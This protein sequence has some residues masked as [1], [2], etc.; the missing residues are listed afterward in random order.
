MT[1]IFFDKK[2]YFTKALYAL[3]KK[4]QLNNLDML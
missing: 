3:L 2:T 1:E 4:R